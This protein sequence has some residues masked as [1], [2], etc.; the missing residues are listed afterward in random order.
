[1]GIIFLEHGGQNVAG[2]DLILAGVLDMEEGALKEAFKGGG[3]MDL[4]TGFGGNG[5][6]IVLKKGFKPFS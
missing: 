1:M 6:H 2:V 4:Q 5:F 3:L